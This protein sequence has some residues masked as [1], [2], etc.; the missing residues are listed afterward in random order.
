MSP[1]NNAKCVLIFSNLFQAARDMT[2]LHHGFRCTDTSSAFL[3]VINQPVQLPALRRLYLSRLVT[4]KLHVKKC[5][6]SCKTTL[7]AVCLEYIKFEGETDDTPITGFLPKEF[8]LKEVTMRSLSFG[9]YSLYFSKTQELRPCCRNF[10]AS[11]GIDDEK[12]VIVE[13]TTEPQNEITLR[14]DDGDDVKHWL[15]VIDSLRGHEWGDRRSL[16]GCQ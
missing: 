10:R 15:G 13:R 9:Y 16:E 12:W 8:N 4:R 5:L 2:D 11:S 6:R 1:G 3:K 7:D 14:S